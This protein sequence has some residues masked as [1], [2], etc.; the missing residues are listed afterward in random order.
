MDNAAYY[1]TATT[2]KGTPCP[3]KGKHVHPETQK[4]LCGIHYKPA[5]A[6]APAPP[7][8][9]KQVL[10]LLEQL[11]PNPLVVAPALSKKPVDPHPWVALKLPAP[12]PKLRKAV[13][14]RL[15]TRLNRGPNWK[16][17]TAGYIYVFWLRGETGLDYWKIGMTQR[18]PEDRLKEWRAAMPGHELQ[19]KQVFAVD[20]ACVKFVERVVHLYLDHC[21]M[22]RYPVGRRLL[23]KWSATGAEIRDAD[24]HALQPTL[25]AG[26]RVVAMHKM[27]EWFCAP[28]STV[29]VLIEHVIQ[30]FAAKA[31]EN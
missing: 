7:A 10:L 19:V 3:Y 2:Q 15:V 4:R 27:V 31:P 9:P 20:A 22:H 1:C 11:P 28:W 26:E 5:P 30:V 8:K 16:S 25:K 17:D 13:C 21:R 14:G 29:Q 23:S 12:D 24:W 6:P 18:T